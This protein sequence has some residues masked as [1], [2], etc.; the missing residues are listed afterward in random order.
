MQ[1]KEDKI[2][3]SSGMDGSIGHIFNFLTK[4]GDNVGVLSPT[5]A[6]YYVYSKFLK[7]NYLNLK[8]IKFNTPV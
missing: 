7:S 5:Y 1:V 6:M 2:L 8:I 3:I 4:P